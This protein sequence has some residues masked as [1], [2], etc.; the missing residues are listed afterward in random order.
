MPQTGL[1]NDRSKKLGSW[2]VFL[3]SRRRLG[4]PVRNKFIQKILGVESK[5]LGLNDFVKKKLTK[6]VTMYTI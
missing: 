3:Q 4:K 1:T 6:C 5:E 2:G